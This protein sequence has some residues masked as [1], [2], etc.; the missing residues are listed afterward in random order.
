MIAFEI[1]L[2][3]MFR[4]ISLAL[5]TRSI[6]E[7][8]REHIDEITRYLTTSELSEAPWASYQ[9]RKIAGCACTGN[10]G[11]VF[12]ATHFKGNR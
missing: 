10:A 8:I 5:E 1:D 3:V 12:P 9:I 6:N 4:V 7:P 2:S 11:N